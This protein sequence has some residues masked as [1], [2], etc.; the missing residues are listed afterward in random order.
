MSNP[1]LLIIDVQYAIDDPSW[2]D[3]RNNRDAES[4]MAALLAHW[5]ERRWPVFHIRHSSAGAALTL[6]SE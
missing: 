4:K 3:E 2:G 1:S 5:R 6:D